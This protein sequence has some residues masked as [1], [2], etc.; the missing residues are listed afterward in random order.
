[1][2]TNPKDPFGMITYTVTPLISS[3]L[4]NIR[5]SVVVYKICISL[6]MMK[7]PSNIVKLLQAQ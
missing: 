4:G 1:M 7:C 5:D 2:R 3:V 6:I